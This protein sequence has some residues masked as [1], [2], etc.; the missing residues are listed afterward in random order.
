MGNEIVCLGAARACS[1]CPIE[2]DAVS[3]NRKSVVPGVFA[4]LVSRCVRGTTAVQPSCRAHVPQAPG[5]GGVA[6]NAR[7]VLEMFEPE[8][9]EAKVK[10]T[11]VG[12]ALTP[13]LEEA[14]RIYGKQS[15]ETQIVA[16]LAAG[17]ILGKVLSRVGR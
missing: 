17:L 1:A 5:R 14:K 13:M 10:A 6:V 16:G 11:Q 3:A 7:D 4:H 12:A 9:A 8:L 2:R 15:R